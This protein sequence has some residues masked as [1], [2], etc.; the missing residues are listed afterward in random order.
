MSVKEAAR[1]AQSNNFMGLV[2]RLSL[3][4]RQSLFP[5]SQTGLPDSFLL[6]PL[7]SETNLN[8]LQEMVPALI[9]SIKELGL[10][11]V[12]DTSSSSSSSPSSAPLS[13][14]G[15][16]NTGQFAG[17]STSGI[18]DRAFRMPDGVNGLMKG[19][20]V[21]RFNETIDM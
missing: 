10:V 13:E 3:L 12:A 21:L 9:E 18:Q 19:N 11:L 14:Q 2:C 5:S 15:A 1:M 16:I 6:L 7:H 17:R 20:G 4:V 8:N